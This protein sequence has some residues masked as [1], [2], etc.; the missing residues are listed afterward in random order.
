VAAGA[1]LLTAAAV[2]VAA[3]WATRYAFAIA[4]LRRGV[5]DTVFCTADGRP[6]FRMDEQHEEVPLAAIAPSLRQAVVAIEDRRFYRHPGIDP[7]GIG[8]AV[9]RDVRDQ[10]LAEGGSTLTQQLARTLFLSNSRTWGRKAKEAALALLIERQLDKEQILELYLNRVYLGGS[11]YGVEPM[12]KRLFGKHA[13]DLSLSESA[14]IAG[15]IRAPS[16]LSPWSNPDGAI[17]RS[18]VVLGRMREEGMISS[19]DLRAAESD[20]PVF[21]PLAA[22]AGAR[23][24]YVQDYLRQQFRNQF[25][26]DHPPEWQVRTTIVRQLQEAAERAVDTGLRRLGGSALQAVLVAFDPRTGDLLAMVGGRS[27]HETSYNRATRSRRQPGSAFKPFVYA[28]ALEQGLSPV[29]VLSGLSSMAPIGRE[30]WAPRNAHLES[31]DDLTLRAALL[32]SNN[33]AAV[34]LQQKIGTTTVVRLAG[35]IGLPE[36]PDV[37][38]LALGTGLVSPFDLT[39]AYAVFPNGGWRVTPRSI[40]SVVNG[41]G[42]TVFESPVA[43]ERVLSEDVAFQM[44]SMLEDVVERGTGTGVRAAGVRFPVGG[45]TGTTDDFKD[46]WFVG[47][48]TSVVAGVWVGSD[49]PAPIGPD[50]YG[51]RVALPIWSEFMRSAA[52]VLG[53]PQPFEAPATLRQELLC[54]TS[55]LRPVEDCPTYTEYFKAGDEVPTRACPI[56]AGSLK[57]RIERAVGGLLDVLGRRL[58]GLLG[59]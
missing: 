41:Q 37:P 23:S 7:I 15:V 48:S 31:E 30:E 1:V 33:R 36:Q 59:R 56:H 3:G 29:S 10:Q 6:W 24:G 38:S 35:R 32:E 20:R 19:D 16:S 2:L 52:K 5:G 14:V 57:Q 12:A 44:V 43:R 13:K 39:L 47:F 46:A 18:H 22:S 40:A 42:D 55:Y 51:S 45:K 28:A 27:F 50:S 58:K 26:G 53:P 49:Q 17:R 8:R 34:A 25:G 54:R 9:S 4:R 21:R 11:I